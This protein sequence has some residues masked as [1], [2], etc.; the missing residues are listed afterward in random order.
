M[1]DVAQN[2]REVGD[3]ARRV[4]A[5]ES[6]RELLDSQLPVDARIAQLDGGARAIGVGQSQR[7]RRGTRDLDPRRPRLN[8]V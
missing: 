8:A 7:Q 2:G 6:F 5:L 1:R 3:R 4:R